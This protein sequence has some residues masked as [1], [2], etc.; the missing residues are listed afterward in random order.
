MPTTSAA[1][2][3]A[4]CSLLDA[5]RGSIFRLTGS[6]SPYVAKASAQV[7]QM[8]Q[9]MFESSYTHEREIAQEVRRLGGEPAGRTSARP[10]EPYLEFLSQR[11]LIPKLVGEKELLIRFFENALHSIGHESAEVRQIIQR[12]LAQHKAD[13]ESLRQT[14]QRDG[15]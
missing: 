10:E 2:L 12:Q 4:L 11:F 15:G 9:T 3:D 14:G 6:D 8:L 7:R 1:V 13:L 5:E